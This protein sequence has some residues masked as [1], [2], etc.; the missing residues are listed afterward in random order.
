MR[1]NSFVGMRHLPVIMV[2]SITGDVM[3]FNDAVNCA[4]WLEIPTQEILDAC[5]GNTEKVRS[6]YYV[7]WII[8]K[9]IG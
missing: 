5:N 9:E 3:W 2:D 6:K 1:T 4:V 7:D 8:E